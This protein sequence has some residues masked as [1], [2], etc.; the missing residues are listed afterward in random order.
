MLTRSGFIVARNKQLEKELTVVP[1]VNTDYAPKGIPFRV[2]RKNKD[3]LCIPQHFG[4]NKFGEPEEDKRPEP[5]KQTIA[6]KGTMKPELRQDEA[7]A[8]IM[9]SMEKN[10][11]AILSLPTGYGK[12]T[13]S[14]KIASLLGL[15]TLVLVHK[16]FLLNQWKERIKQFCET[17]VGKIQRD[18]FDIEHPFVIGMLQTFVSR[19]F[20]PE[21]FETF[22][23]VI[24]DEA[25]HIC[26][27]VFSQAMLK[28]CPKYTLGLTATPDRKDGLTDVLYWCLGPSA[29]IVKREDEEATLDV[30]RPDIELYKKPFPLSRFGKVSMQEAITNLVD[31][32]ERNQLILEKV[33]K[34]KNRKVLVLTDRRHHCKWLNENLEG[35]SLYIGQMKEKDLDISSKSNIVIGT[36]SMAQEGLD[37]GDVDTVFLTTPKSDIVQ[38][39]GRCMREGGQ[40]R[41]TPM[42]IDLHDKWGPF[43]AMFYKRR[44]VY[45]S[46]G[47]IKDEKIKPLKTF[48]FT[49][50]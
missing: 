37:I 12:T 34:L 38:A 3:V 44:K 2:F 29:F 28:M 31:D 20:P 47:M 18:V 10:K 41:N 36:F 42:I 39:I 49:Q 8:R 22:G 33:R 17:S 32:E 50:I 24:V 11:G 43:E 4:R 40:R 27:R 23:L 21:S 35:S 45:V 48:S 19:D 1:E 30:M 7:V 9:E 5:L 25:H 13:V 14:L 6:F 46:M 26:A 16:E 15:R